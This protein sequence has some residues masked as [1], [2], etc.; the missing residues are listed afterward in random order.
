MCIY[1]GAS[2][3]TGGLRVLSRT[4]SQCSFKMALTAG[5]FSMYGS[6]ISSDMSMTD[7]FLGCFSQ[8]M[9]YVKI[10]LI[11]LSRSLR[12]QPCTPCMRS[13]LS[14]ANVIGINQECPVAR[15]SLCHVCSLM[16]VKPPVSKAT[17][18]G[19]DMFTCCGEVFL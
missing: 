8:K 11:S 4:R 18:C 3:C 10:C 6:Y 12:V 13:N 1:R 5:Y 15:T 16:R 2:A 19:V 17:R 7:R 14:R 9:L